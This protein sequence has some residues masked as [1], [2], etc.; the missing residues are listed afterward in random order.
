[1]QSGPPWTLRIPPDP[2]Y[3]LPNQMH[4]LAI[5]PRRIEIEDLTSTWKHSGWFPIKSG[6]AVW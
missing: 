2:G 4:V 6:F 3:E 5:H 1:M